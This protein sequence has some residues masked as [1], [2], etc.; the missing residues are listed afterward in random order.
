MRHVW[1]ILLLLISTATSYSQLWKKHRVEIFAGL[2]V[3]HYF[4]DIGGTAAA[5]DLFGFRDL[6]FRT[7][8][9]GFSAGA[10]YRVNERL[11]AQ[12]AGSFAFLGN[13]DKGSRN[14]WRD[15]SF[16][17]YGTEITA[18]ALF[19]IIPESNQNYYNIMSLRGGLRHTNK[20]F[21]LYAFAGVGG[22]FYNVSPK[23]GLAAS[24]RFND[25]D[26]FAPVI[27]FGVGVKFQLMQRLV[28]SAELGARYAFTDYLDGV[29][30]QPSEHNDAYHV[31]LFK[32][33]Y[34]LPYDKM[35]QKI[36]RRF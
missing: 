29:S 21:S 24:P 1:V 30:P 3:L 36:R 17:T 20:I 8:R 9:P 11:Y 10:I 13:S 5:D 19:Y 27:P 22:L 4:G 35:L 34:R 6:R 23:S 26:S 16:A 28:L 31:L 18:T 33:H 32:L 15:Y 12:A 7:L 25:A 14:A 2:P